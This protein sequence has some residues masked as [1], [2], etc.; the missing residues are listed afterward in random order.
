MNG[1]MNGSGGGRSSTHRNN[2]PASNSR[3]RLLEE[4]LRGIHVP[5]NR[6]IS[7]T[8][9]AGV[10]P[11]AFTTLD[12][13]RLA[14]RHG[15]QAPSGGLMQELPFHSLLRSTQY[16]S[17]LRAAS[18]P[19]SRF[20]MSNNAPQLFAA[21]ER[22]QG[23][24]MSAPSS[25]LG[26]IEIPFRPTAG[27]QSNQVHDQQECSVRSLAA[28]LSNQGTV[29]FSGRLS[30]AADL[31]LSDLTPA[32]GTSLG[33]S[34]SIGATAASRIEGPQGTRALHSALYQDTR[35]EVLNDVLDDDVLVVQDSAG[36]PMTKKPRLEWNTNTPPLSIPLGIE[37]DPNWLSEFQCIL[38][39]DLIEV[40]QQKADVGR[41]AAKAVSPK[42]IGI[43]CRWCVNVSSA[44]RVC[45]SSAYPSSIRQV[46]PTFY[47]STVFL[48]FSAS[49]RYTSSPNPFPVLH[50]S[51]VLIL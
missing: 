6:Y 18:I 51:C 49:Q 41:K 25:L 3:K 9:G 27:A 46:C 14:H 30:R 48:L 12:Q 23:N 11:N 42:Q 20:L 39:A 5:A 1:N 7:G 34:P 45:R 35:E 22:R 44:S 38:R 24:N 31:L 15:P 33:F 28:L 17:G 26:N 40:V 50:L 36:Q 47:R 21:V 2:D 43:R 8:V 32:P 10:G 13:A 4:V 16:A 19:P 37:E 29:D